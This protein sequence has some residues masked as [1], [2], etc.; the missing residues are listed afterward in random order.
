MPSAAATRRGEPAQRAEREGIMRRPSGA[1]IVVPGVRP[2]S[3]AGWRSL[4]I[5]SNPE[6]ARRA[7]CRS[8]RAYMR[9]ERRAGAEMGGT[10]R[11]RSAC[12]HASDVSRAQRDCV[13]A[14]IGVGV[15]VVRGAACDDGGER[16]PARQPAGRSPATERRAERRR[17]GVGSR[18]VV[19][20]ARECHGIV[21]RGARVR[22]W[23]RQQASCKVPVSRSP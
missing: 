5:R 11:C 4:A 8:A 6:R 21:L 9:R 16:E 3:R 12:G 1:R 14:R 7:R 23:T 15:C 22:G 13:R 10:G 18:R 2:R 20:R 19:S 17:C